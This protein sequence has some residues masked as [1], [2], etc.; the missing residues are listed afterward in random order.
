M[1]EVAKTPNDKELQH[2]NKILA[3]L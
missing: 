2:K 1:L 3:E